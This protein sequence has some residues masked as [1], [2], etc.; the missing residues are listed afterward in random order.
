MYWSS[1]DKTITSCTQVPNFYNIRFS[2][3]PIWPHTISSI[4]I[5]PSPTLP[6]TFVFPPTA[7]LSTRLPR[8]VLYNLSV[9]SYH[10]TI[11]KCSSTT[12]SL[13]YPFYPLHL[14]FASPPPTPPRSC[15]PVSVT[16]SYS[17]FTFSNTY[18]RLHI[19]HST[20]NR[21]SY[22]SLIHLPVSF[23]HLLIYLYLSSPLLPL[24]SQHLYTCTCDLS[25][26]SLHII[27]TIALT[28]CT[29]LRAFVLLSDTRIHFRQPH[30]LHNQVYRHVFSYLLYHLD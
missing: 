22:R 1:L 3:V 19:I 18:P 10:S 17:Y 30:Q 21:C 4:G 28:T 9:T 12:C 8:H 27:C 2:L 29:L 6:T 11:D 25:S 26:T 24:S 5:P 13:A 14:L 16:S 23:H 20:I 7:V 15:V